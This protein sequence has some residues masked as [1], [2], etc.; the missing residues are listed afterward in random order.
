MLPVTPT[1][2]EPAA[3]AAAAPAR[4]AEPAR[5]PWQ[6]WAEILLCSGYPTQIVLGELLK[7]AGIAPLTADGSLSA[8][9]VF[10]L[11]LGDTVVLVTLMVWLL[12]RGGESPR[13]VF[14]GR[15][16]ASAEAAVGLLSVPFVVAL[17]VALSLLIRAF[18]PFLHN[19][20]ANP[21]DGLLGTQTGLL[22]FLVVVIVAG[23]LREEL[24]RAFLLHRFR[25][26]LGQTG[27]GLV[28]TSVAF[29]L[30]HTLQ[31][32]DAAILTGAL[33]ATWGLIYLTRGSAIA[34]I[35]SHSLFNTGEL[36]RA[37]LR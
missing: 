1:D 3:F 35:V 4:P 30:G 20:P 2:I 32:W 6:P 16:R 11:S 33:G 18:L 12:I 23:G 13:A 14:L 29:G 17:V 19:V 5:R 22:A 9:F 21:L 15:R 37:F 10:A 7:D 25:H 8:T 31:G 26:D 36:L 27:A 34:P 28:V 24:Q